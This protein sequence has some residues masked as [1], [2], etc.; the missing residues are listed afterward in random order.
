[1]RIDGAFE[2]GVMDQICSSA[3]EF[4]RVMKLAGNAVKAYSP[5]TGPVPTNG[6]KKRL[7]GCASL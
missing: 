6:R 1:M 4:W 2:Q 5:G 3:D 7:G